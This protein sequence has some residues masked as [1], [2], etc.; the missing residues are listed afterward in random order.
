MDWNIRYENFVIFTGFSAPVL[1]GN[2]FHP[3]HWL[4]KCDIFIYELH[5]LASF[6]K[7]RFII[8]I[9]VQPS[10]CVQISIHEIASARFHQHER[11]KGSEKCIS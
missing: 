5:H 11:Y 9:I 3:V 1:S 7:F 10:F 2:C 8:L 6:H 4:S